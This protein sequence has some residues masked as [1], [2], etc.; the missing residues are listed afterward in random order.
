M[1]NKLDIG[2]ISDVGKKRSVN[3]DYFGS[4]QL[5]YGQLIVV[6]D[7]MGGHKG[8]EMASRLG[9]QSIKEHFDT[10]TAQSDARDALR[11]AIEKAN[12]ALLSYAEKNP[13]FKGMGSTVVALLIRNGEAFYGHVGDSRIYFI[14]AGQIYQL[15]KDHSLVQQLIDANIVKPEDAAHHPQKNVVVK[16]LGNKVTAEPDI[17]EAMAL[18][19]G[20]KFLLCSDGLTAY[21]QNDELLKITTEMP[22]MQAATEL[23]RVANERGGKDNI[24]VQIVHIVKGKRMPRKI[25]IDR[26]TAGGAVA[27]LVA[28]ITVL[29]W[30]NIFQMRQAV[31]EKF[32]ALRTQTDTKKSTTPEPPK[33]YGPLNKQDQEIENS[34]QSNSTVQGTVKEPNNKQA[35]ESKSP[36]KKDSK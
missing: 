32:D 7:G 1:K 30:F 13:E 2:N 16:A 35:G 19:K 12:S 31:T 15:T 24:T 27:V 28:V 18:F 29:F 5:P 36:P 21:L 26:K 9:V 3:E 22:T 17:S 33:P 34:K 20:D 6:C 10:L 8:G 23:V 25:T 4:F 11:D 14:R